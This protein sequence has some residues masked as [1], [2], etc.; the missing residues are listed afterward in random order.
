MKW[1]GQYIQSFTARFRNDVYLEDISTGTIASGGNLGLD[2]NNKIV[3]A[4]VSSGTPTDITV[5]NEGTDTT[6]FPLF[7]TAATGDLGPKTNSNLSFNSNT[8]TLSC[9]G[10]SGNFVG[11][12]TG[13]ADSAD[14]LATA[15]T[16]AGVSFN[17]SANISLNNNAI[18]N[19]AGYTTNTGDITSV[20]LVSDSGTI[21]GL[22]DAISFTI[23][24]GTNISTS[25]TGTTLTINNDLAGD[26]TDVRVTADDSNSIS[27]NSG[28]AS[29][30]I[31]GGEG[32]DTSV[33]STTMT[34]AGEDASTSNKGVASFSAQNFAVDAGAVSIKDEGVSLTDNVTGVLPAANGGRLENYSLVSSSSTTTTSA[35]D[36]EAN[37][38]VIPYDTEQLVSSTNTVVLT[39]ASGITGVSGSTYSW[40]SATQGDWE[41]QWN[42]LSNT[43]V[44][45]NRI[46]SGV[47]LQRGTHDGS[48]MTW[49]DYDPSTSFIYDRG[50]GSVRKGSTT[51]Q[52]LVTQGATQYY[53]RLMVWKEESSNAATTAITVV[54]GV[55]LIIKQIS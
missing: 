50:T 10:F 4:T 19:G 38:V 48:T 25:A 31:A 14:I 52:T 55:S 53:W 27:F 28:S 15:R 20:S 39:G 37:A 21:N 13:T 47:K 9:L 2:S 12:L 22:T 40:Y 44:A 49:T 5:A 16:I 23:A 26:I 34:I 35:T 11:D 42:V 46:L 36:G 33:S 45:N 24:G 29:F 32:I 41:Y 8:S 17:G 18:T 7:V 54:T 6:C 1:L 30:T 51:N 43:N 3:K